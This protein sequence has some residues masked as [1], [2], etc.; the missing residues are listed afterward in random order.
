ME[1]HGKSW[2]NHGKIMEKSG[3]FMAMNHENIMGNAQFN[4][5]TTT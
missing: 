1:N 3:G 2:K 4:D 5:E